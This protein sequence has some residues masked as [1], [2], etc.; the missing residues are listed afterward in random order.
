MFIEMD[1]MIAGA[2][3]KYGDAEHRRGRHDHKPSAAAVKIMIDT[4]LHAPSPIVPHIDLGD[5][6]DYIAALAATGDYENP[7]DYFVPFGVFQRRQS[8]P[9]AAVRT[10]HPTARRALPV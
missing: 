5:P 8:D 6:D 4:Y 9:R 2:G 10:G 7:A 1:A 3:T